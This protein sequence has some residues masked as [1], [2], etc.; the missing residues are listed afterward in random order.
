[1]LKITPAQLDAVNRNRA[2]QAIP[3]LM[4]GLRQAEPV[5][6]H[7]YSDD[8]MRRIVE[9]SIAR[10]RDNGLESRGAVY[11]Y[12]KLFI[13]CQGD[14]PAERDGYRPLLDLLADKGLSEAERLERAN[15]ML[16]DPE[17]SLPPEQRN[18]SF[19]VTPEPDI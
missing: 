12:G 7:R 13:A 19:A 9:A 6:T 2:V 5:L 10:A 4:L 17:E 18:R 1:M 15:A 8:L 16:L 3:E 14:E 11:I